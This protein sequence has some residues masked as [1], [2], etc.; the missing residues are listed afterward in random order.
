ML[1]QGLRDVSVYQIALK[2]EETTH[3]AFLPETIRLLTD[4]SF[5]IPMLYMGKRESN[6]KK[7]KAKNDC[8]EEKKR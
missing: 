8:L 7:L 1:K 4:E 2:N 6:V 3:R 5:S